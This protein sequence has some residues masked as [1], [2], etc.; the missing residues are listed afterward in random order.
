MVRATERKASPLEEVPSPSRESRRERVSQETG[1]SP[2]PLVGSTGKPVGRIVSPSTFVPSGAQT[3]RMPVHAC[4]TMWRPPSRCSFPQCVKGWPA[5]PRSAQS[6][7]RRGRVPRRAVSTT[8]PPSRSVRAA[9]RTWTERMSPSVST[10]RCRFLPQ[11]VCSPVVASCIATDGTGGDRWTVEHRCTGF[12]FLP[13]GDTPLAPTCLMHP[14]PGA[15][16]FPLRNRG[17]DRQPSWNIRWHVPPGTGAPQ[18]RHH[19]MHDLSAWHVH[20]PSPRRAWRDHWF[21]E[22]PCF[23]CDV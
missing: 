23:L 21:H 9:G 10:T 3:P 4:V 11:I 8:V 16:A 5:D 14:F 12:R 22:S 18:H 1:R 13:S 17:G 20:W 7:G 6:T 19:R 2:I 15:I